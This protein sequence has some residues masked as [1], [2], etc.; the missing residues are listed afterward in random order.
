MEE[1]GPYFARAMALGGKLLCHFM[2]RVFTLMIQASRIF[3]RVNV[4]KFVKIGNIIIVLMMN[5]DIT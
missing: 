2:I 1:S 4:V 5:Y 3:Y